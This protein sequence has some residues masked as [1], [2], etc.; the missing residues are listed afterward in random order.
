M[1]NQQP[2]QPAYW[3]A[4]VTVTPCTAFVG[5]TVHLIARSVPV[6][7]VTAV[8][9]VVTFLVAYTVHERVV[10]D[11]RARWHVDRM[12]MNRPRPRARRSPDR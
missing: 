3:K 10:H 7:L 11:W 5:W 9:V 4:L 12:T 2:P 8:S 6:P 1:L